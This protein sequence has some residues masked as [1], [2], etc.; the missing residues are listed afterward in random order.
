MPE[1]PHEQ[2]GSVWGTFTPAGMVP[3]AEIVIPSSTGE[4]QNVGPVLIK[5]PG[6]FRSVGCSGGHLVG[7]PEGRCGLHL[8]H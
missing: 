7:D 4:E 1:G 5:L 8:H 3:P 2:R 6:S